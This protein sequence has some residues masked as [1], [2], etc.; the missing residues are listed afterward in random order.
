VIKKVQVIPQTSSTQIPNSPTT[1]EDSASDSENTVP[2]KTL[3]SSSQSIIHF[4]CQSFFGTIFPGSSFEYLPGMVA[5]EFASQCLLSSV[6]A[7]ALAKLA[8]E[9]KDIRL[10]H[11][12]RAIHV[13]AIKQVNLA[14]K[15]SK[16]VAKNSTLVATLILGLFEAIILNDESNQLVKSSVHVKNCFDNWVA[17]TNGTMSLIRY[18][19]KELLQTDFGKRI[20]VFTASRIR[21]NSVQLRVRMPEQAVELNRV[22]IPHMDQMDGMFLVVRCWN[23]GDLMVDLVAKTRGNKPSV[24]ARTDTFQ[25]RTTVQ[26]K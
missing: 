22:M 20:Y 8:S 4:A 7:V 11:H 19:G 14:L 25:R 21:A 6:H 13:K 18:R 24:I 9:K 12:S 1:A 10:V 3:F 26:S 16:E 15:S 5:G 2:I 17:H 23:L